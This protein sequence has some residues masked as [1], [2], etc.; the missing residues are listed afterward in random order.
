MLIWWP[1]GIHPALYGTNY[2]LPVGQT[3][4]FA[5]FADILGYPLPPA[6]NCVYA[7]NSENAHV[8]RQNA[9]KIRRPGLQRPGSTPWQWRSDMKNF[10]WENNNNDKFESS[11]ILRFTNNKKPIGDMEYKIVGADPSEQFLTAEDQTVSIE[12]W[13]RIRF[14]ILEH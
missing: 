5:T 2:D 4:F 3:D 14:R 8:H 12:I 13:F 6:A 10:D 11:M 1:K 7:F 9:T